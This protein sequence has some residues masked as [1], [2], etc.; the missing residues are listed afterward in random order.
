MNAIHQA[1][2]RDTGSGLQK[3]IL[4]THS[5][6]R[7]LALR[8]YMILENQWLS[9]HISFLSTEAFPS[10]T[11]RPMKRLVGLGKI[12][13]HEWNV[14]AP[15]LEPELFIARFNVVHTTHLSWSD[16]LDNCAVTHHETQPY[17]SRCVWRPKWNAMQVD[18]HT[19]RI[20]A[21]THDSPTRFWTWERYHAKCRAIE[22]VT[23]VWVQ[24][25]VN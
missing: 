14:L 20:N 17:S 2:R 3:I 24:V 22:P 9:Q 10:V 23:F 12:H 4:S 18:P 11:R 7:S 1:N 6:A 5:T 25:V 16:L 8:C 21:L 13:N 19:Y 15:A